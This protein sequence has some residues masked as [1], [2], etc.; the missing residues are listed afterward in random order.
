MEENPTNTQQSISYTDMPLGTDTV[1]LVMPKGMYDDMPY[2]VEEVQVRHLGS[3]LHESLCK[4]RDLGTLD[5]AIAHYAA[6]LEGADIA[7]APTLAR[8]KSLAA[9]YMANK[10]D[11]AK[12]EKTFR[13]ISDLLGT[14]KPI[15]RMEVE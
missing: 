8:M 2:Q 15:K 3:K 11:N 6:V 12:A 10:H 14:L 9:E 1:S 13:K 7:D 5:K 4:A